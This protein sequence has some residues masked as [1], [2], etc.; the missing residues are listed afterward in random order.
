MS[1]KK[2]FRMY[3]PMYLGLSIL[4]MVGLHR[5]AP[6]MQLIDWPLRYVGGAIIIVSLLVGLTARIMFARAGTAIKPFEESKKLIV[7][8]PY[9]FTRNPIYLSMTALLVGTAVL[10]GSLTPFLVVPA[11]FFIIKRDFVPVEEAMLAKTFGA[12]FDA[13]R[14]RVRRWL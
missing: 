4:L 3:P 9:R 12:E 8:G 13:Y 2:A 6:V 1:E 10:L 11:F 7:V 14:A 5:F